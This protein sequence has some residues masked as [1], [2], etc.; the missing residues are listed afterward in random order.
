[1]EIIKYPIKPEK[2]KA[3][4]F[5]SHQYFTKQASN[6]VAEYIKHF[7]KEGDLIL[8][9]FGG[10]GVTG[11]EAIA[12]RRKVIIMDINPLACFIT[13]QLIKKIDTHKLMG[14]FLKL[15]QKIKPIIDN[16]YFMNDKKI[17]KERLTNWYPKSIYLPQNSDFKT[18]DELFTRRQL[19]SYSL[20]LHEIN[21]IKDKE[22][23]DMLKFV[24]SATMSKVNLTYWDNKNR[25]E[26]GGGASIFGAYRYHK[27]KNLTELNVWKN[28]AKRFSYILKGKI[29]WNKLTHNYDVEKNFQV[30]NDSILNINKYVKENSIDYIYTDPPYGGNIAY[31][32]LSTMWNAWLRFEVNDKM[33]KEEIIEG[34]DQLK[35]QKDYEMLLSQS[36]AA[37]GKVLKKD[38]WMSLVFAHKK[39]EFW[40]IIIDACESNA[41]EF[42]GS[43]Y[44]PTNNSSIHYKK[45]PANV[46]CSQ[47]IA[48]FQKTFQISPKEKPDDLKDY[49]VNEI[50]RACLESNGSAIDRIYNRVL[51]KL[52]NNNTIH[53]AKRRGYLKL[54][55]ILENESLFVFEPSSG[56]YY[57]KDHDKI[58]NVFVKDYF[59]H[60]D[61]F[62]VYLRSM[63]S[64]SEGLTLSEIHK[65]LFEIFES[66]IRFP[67]EKDLEEVLLDVA[68][69]SKK[70]SKWQLKGGEQI[71]LLFE[72]LITNRLVRIKNENHSHSE[73]IYRL[74]IIGNYLG[75]HSWIGKKEQSNDS[76]EGIKLSEYSISSIPVQELSCIQK[77][78]IQQIDVIWFDKMNIPRYAFEIEESTSITTGIERF[79]YLLE[80]DKNISNNLCVVVPKARKRKLE[81]VFR[82][83]STFIGHPYYMENKV[84]FI[85]KEDLENFYNEH[86]KTSKQ[87]NEVDFKK[88]FQR[89]EIE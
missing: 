78:R 54:D 57:V 40:N 17:E 88:L 33:K 83:E 8:D 12:L 19:L 27:P 48:N 58:D 24:F 13:K 76:Y 74:I 43:T 68:F 87:F 69:K 35:S 89:I 37:M 61:E 67:I 4:H 7:S 5:K 11:I 75:M 72:N 51:D 21:R 65:G 32:D 30:I 15:E 9:P 25:G 62:K 80:V 10:T 22:I 47:R 31:L 55:N 16:Y 18:V 41:L 3:W 53:E 86:A 77:E 82:K 73:M 45:N 28:F 84:G 64:K 14:S 29:H 20:L 70:T 50:E 85:F 71:E 36:L 23:K 49:I 66:D 39:L 46:L 34:G 2:E 38:K 6:V 1:M 56:L 63:L 79:S 52:H 60:K 42:K 59:K 44:Q 26:E 81:K